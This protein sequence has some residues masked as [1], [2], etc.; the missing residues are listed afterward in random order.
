MPESTSNLILSENCAESELPKVVEQNFDDSG[1]LKGF[2][3]LVD[4][5][6]LPLTGVQFSESFLPKPP[7]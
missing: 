3:L 1:K 5:G 6:E 7:Q 4:F 2:T